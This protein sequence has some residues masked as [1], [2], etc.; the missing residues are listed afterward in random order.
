M[1]KVELNDETK[2]WFESLLSKFS[3]SKTE[4]AEE[5]VAEEVELEDDKEEEKEKEEVKMM[6]DAMKAEI[7]DMIQSVVAE[8]MKAMKGDMEVEMSKVKK[9]NDDLKVELKRIGSQPSAKAKKSQPT[10]KSVGSES[11]I[12]FL[13][14]VT[15]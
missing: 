7:M 15:Q 10:T 1:N 3:N 9:E 4:L 13:N 2:N 8:A 11:M 6:D 14:R 12:E 5:K